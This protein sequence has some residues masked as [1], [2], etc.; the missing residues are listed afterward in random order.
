VRPAGTDAHDQARVATPEAAL[1]AGADLLVIG[2]A[3]TGAADPGAAAAA[4]AATLRRQAAPL[5]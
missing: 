4:I 2:R 5:T 1:A 3:I